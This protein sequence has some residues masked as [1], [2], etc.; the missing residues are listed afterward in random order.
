MLS[1]SFA[2]LNSF[3]F[4]GKFWGIIK[5]LSRLDKCVNLEV[6]LCS[7]YSLKIKGVQLR[8]AL[9]KAGVF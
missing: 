1:I 6:K 9:R 8:K 2:K 3:D 5:T 7:K 4:W